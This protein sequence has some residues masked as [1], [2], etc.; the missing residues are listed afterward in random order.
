MFHIIHISDTY[1]PSSIEEAM[2]SRGVEIRKHK[3]KLVLRGI[4]KAKLLKPLL[5]TTLQYIE[6]I[7]TYLYIFRFRYIF[8]SVHFMFTY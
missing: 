7:D 3:E 8:R 6:L 5:F 4:L 2:I 1:Y